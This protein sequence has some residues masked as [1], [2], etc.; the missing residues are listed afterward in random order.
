MFKVGNFGKTG[1][2]KIIVLT[3]IVL[4]LLIG[5][6][7][8]WQKS[9]R[10]IKG[11][12]EDYAVIETAEGKFV[13]NEKAGLT[14][15]VPEGWI[16]EKIEFKEGSVVFYSPDIESVREDKKLTPSFKKGC[17][18]G[19]AVGYQKTSFEEIRKKIE[20]AHESL[21]IKSD[22]FE[23][24]NIDGIAALKNSFESVDLG[25]STDVFM[26][27]KEN[28]VGRVALV[29]ALQDIE[30]CTQEFNQFLKSVSIQ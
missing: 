15:K 8:C 7:F 17:T 25:Y 16:E 26:M 29:A 27:L 22:E 24:I 20:S 19:I 13:I 3:V 14:V 10:E 2:K 4:L 30:R 5:G 21:I 18:I 12:P 9:Q 6:V 11:S 1:K 28:I 23:I